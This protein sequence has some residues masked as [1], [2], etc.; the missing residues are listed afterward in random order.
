[1]IIIVGAGAHGLSLAYHLKK[2][3]IKDV[4]I[5]EMKRIGYGSSSRNASRYR[6]HFYSEENIDYALKA[7]P[8]LVSRSKELFLN[9]VTYKTGYLWILRSEEQISIFKKL[10]SLWKSKNI[11]GRF[12]NCKEF[13][14]LSVEGVC[15]YAPQD[16]AFHH[17]YILYSYYISVKDSYKIVF[18]KVSEIVIGSGKVKGIKTESGK[19]FEAEKVVLTTGAWSGE[20]LQ[21]INIQPYIEPERKEIFITEPIKYFIKPL[22]IDKDIYFSQTLKGEIIGGT[23][24]KTERG[25]LP[26]TI[27]IKEMSKFLQG[28]KQLVKNISGLGILRGWSGYY[29]M[30]PDNSHIMGYGEEWPEHLYIDAG[31]SGHGMMFAPYSGKLM[32][33]LIADNKKDPSFSIFTPDRFAKN[34]LLKENLV[35]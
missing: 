24:T 6:Y 13:D 31:Y 1:M 8:Y 19:F 32:A 10:D 3:G 30:T 17:D 5:I 9:S 21:K 18:D 29:E 33:D 22:I 35:I 23:E 34:K 27:S 2:K 12:I 16:G 20:L 15:Y 11:G 28:L 25:F 4:L 7:I 14:Y 26:F